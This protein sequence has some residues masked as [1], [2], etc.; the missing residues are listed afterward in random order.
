MVVEALYHDGILKPVKPID[1]AD[2]EWVELEI[3]RRRPSK[4]ANVVSLKGIWSRHIQSADEGDWV[5]D[6]IAEIRRETNLKLD[7]LAAELSEALAD[8]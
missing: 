7:R 3:T 6:T 4:P 8:G 1:L 5:S 2:G